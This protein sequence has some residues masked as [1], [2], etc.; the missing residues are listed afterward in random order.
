LEGVPSADFGV[1]TGGPRPEIKINKTCLVSI[2]L[3]TVVSSPAFGDEKKLRAWIDSGSWSQGVEYC[4]GKLAD[5]LSR[6][7]DLRTLST[8]SLA[9][10]ATYC[11]AL[12]SGKGDEFSSGWWWYTAASIDLKTAQSLLPELRKI[13]LLQTL[14]A[15]RKRVLSPGVHVTQ[16]DNRVLLP[17]GE[18]VPGTPPRRTFKPEVPEHMFRPITGVAGS[19]VT[20]KGRTRALLGVCSGPG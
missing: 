11:A 1:P 10:M 18:S 6:R 14:P 19:N 2:L 3:L 9:H 8:A 5:D 17:S 15:P 20:F 4:D 13:G 16:E 12:A 7:P